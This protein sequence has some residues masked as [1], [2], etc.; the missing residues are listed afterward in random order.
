PSEFRFHVAG[1]MVPLFFTVF[2]EKKRTCTPG[3]VSSPPRGGDGLAIPPGPASRRSSSNLPGNP[4]RL[5]TETGRTVLGAALFGLAPDGVCRA[6][7]VAMNAVSSYLAV[8]P[9]PPPEGGR[10]FAF[11]CTFRR[12]AAPGR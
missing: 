7:H 8:S 12:L 2:P 10:R 5:A 11:C 6:V 9:L 1:F 4:P 3:F